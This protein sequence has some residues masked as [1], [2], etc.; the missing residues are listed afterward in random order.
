MMMTRLSR[1]A[2]SCWPAGGVF[3]VLISF[4]HISSSS[5]QTTWPEQHNRLLSQPTRQHLLY[6]RHHLPT[7]AQVAV[8]AEKLD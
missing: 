1:S 6:D 2:A 8:D 7:M 5:T 4:L 3:Y